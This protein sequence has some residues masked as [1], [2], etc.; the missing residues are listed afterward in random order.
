MN[1]AALQ[2]M[3]PHFAFDVIAEPGLGIARDQGPRGT[4]LAMAATAAHVGA[5]RLGHGLSEEY[6]FHFARRSDGLSASRDGTNT[7]GILVALRSPG[8]PDEGQWPYSPARVTPDR[9]GPPPPNCAGPF[10]SW[11]ARRI[12]PTVEL[13]H[14]TLAPTLPVVVALRLTT[15]F[16]RPDGGIVRVV[17]GDM[18]RGATHAVL[19]VGRAT[20]NATSEPY[21]AVRNSWGARWGSDGYGLVQREYLRGRLESAIVLD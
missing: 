6:L 8:Q 2:A 13:V 16:S 17:A 9:P 21:F 19:V 7:T 5:H 4:C 15:R 12:S 14:S 18:E 10:R 3:W 20:E 1:A 11:G